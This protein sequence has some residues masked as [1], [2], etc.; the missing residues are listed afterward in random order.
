MK[1]SLCQLHALNKSIA[2]CFP[3]IFSLI[4]HLCIIYA[5]TLHLHFIE[6]HDRI[7]TAS[8]A[9][10]HWHCA[11]KRY[12]LSFLTKTMT[13]HI[14][15]L[16]IRIYQAGM[17][18]KRMAKKT[19]NV[20]IRGNNAMFVLLFRSLPHSCIQFSCI[21]LATIMHSLLLY[22]WSYQCWTLSSFLSL[23]SFFAHEPRQGKC[24]NNSW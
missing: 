16:Y 23:F 24:I 9:F 19:E 20:I 6:C 15:Y 17:Q 18:C 10:L 3:S 22:F 12:S 13:L 8:L 1:I 7:Y 4:V 14:L 21:C 2:S 5:Y 11:F